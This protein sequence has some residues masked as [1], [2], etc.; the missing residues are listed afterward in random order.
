MISFTDRVV[1]E[2][3]GTHLL[4]IYSYP[5][6]LSPRFTTS[7]AAVMILVA[8][9]SQKKAFHEFQPRAGSLPYLTSATW[10]PAGHIIVVFGRHENGS[11]AYPYHPIRPDQGKRRW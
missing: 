2:D 7:F 5:A 6:S 8:S 9:T 3:K 1:G 10:F 4:L 11:G